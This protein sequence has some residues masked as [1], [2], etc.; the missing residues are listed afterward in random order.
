MTN[1]LKNKLDKLTIEQLFI[2]AQELDNTFW[3]YEDLKDFVIDKIKDDYLTVAA[4][5]LTAL[6]D[7]VAEYYNYDASMGTL[8]SVAP[9]TTKED[10]IDF[11]EDYNNEDIKKV[12]KKYQGGFYNDS[13]TI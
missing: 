12:L 9:I 8:D 6:N 5:V 13:K 10:F 3:C 4:H 11:L 1:T 2:I 7:E